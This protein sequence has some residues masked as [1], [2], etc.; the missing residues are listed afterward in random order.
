MKM[1]IDNLSDEITKRKCAFLCGNGF[2][3][4]FDSGFSNIHNRLYE[5][6]RALYKNTKYKVKSRNKALDQK[7][8]QNYKSVINALKYIAREDFYKIFDDG[9]LFAGSIVQCEGLEAKFR[10]LKYLNYLVFGASQWSS[11][12]SLYKDGIEKGTEKVNI[13]YWTIL[14]YF[15]FAILKLQPDNYCFPANNSFIDMIKKGDISHVQL[16]IED[17]LRLIT[18]LNGFNTYYK[19]LYSFAIYNGGKAI[20]VTNHDKVEDLNLQ[21]LNTFLSNFEVVFTLN[22]DLI[23]ERIIPTKP[24][25]HLHG[26]FIPNMVEYVFYQSY[27]ILKDEMNTISCSDIFIGDYFC[28]KTF[29]AITAHQ[30]CKK[31]PNKKLLMAYDAINESIINYSISEVVIFGMNIN[32]DQ[33]VIRYIMMAFYNAEIDNPKIVYCYFLE[34]EKIE[35]ERQFTAV[36]TF[37]KELSDYSHRIEVSYINTQDVLDSYF[38]N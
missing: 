23:I 27:S 1:T 36:I 20:N 4:N 2:S 26:K 24:I 9:I 35:F 6:H 22:Y 15:Y 21:K 19:M 32:N 25:F 13:E 34:E 16:G 18:L 14:I 5:A 17:K 28:N 12:S 31:Q 37:S 7:L 8:T 3:M 10:E 33:D 11:L 30:A 29:L 38:K